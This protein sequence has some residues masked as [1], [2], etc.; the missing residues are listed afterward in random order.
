EEL[1]GDPGL[2]A[3]SRERGR[4]G[5][6]EREEPVP[7]LRAAPVRRSLPGSS[8]RAPPVSPTPFRPRN[9]RDRQEGGDPRAC[10]GF[11]ASCASADG[12]TPT[13]R[14]RPVSAPRGTGSISASRRGGRRL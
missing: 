2:P 1:S 13:A 9:G 12:A 11:R 4:A 10:G 5:A 8:G 7:E 6:P 3:P 14:E